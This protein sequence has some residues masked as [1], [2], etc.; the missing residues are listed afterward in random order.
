MILQDFDFNDLYII[1]SDIKNVK[2][3]LTGDLLK[4]RLTQRHLP[5]KTILVYVDLNPDKLIIPWL[6]VVSNLEDK[7]YEVRVLTSD[8]EAFGRITS[9]LEFGK[10]LKVLNLQ[11]YAVQEK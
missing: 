6:E 1:V 7:W 4:I 9:F 10:L 3:A 11:F 8:P 2:Y 5:I